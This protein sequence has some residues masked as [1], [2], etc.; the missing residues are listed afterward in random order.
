LSTAAF[1]FT[2][3]CGAAGVAGAEVARKQGVTSA[4]AGSEGIAV[5]ARTI[6]GIRTLNR[7]DFMVPPG[8]TGP[9]LYC[10]ETLWGFLPDVILPAEVL[11]FVTL[12]F[13]AWDEKGP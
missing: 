2:V 7:R 10:G 5:A 6:I 8:V 11:R 13:P 1:V 3:F 9:A 4:L 12:C